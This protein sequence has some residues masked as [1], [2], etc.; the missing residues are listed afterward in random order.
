MRSIAAGVLVLSLPF[1][2][3]APAQTADE[4]V[5][6]HIA[7]LGGRAALGKLN[8]RHSTGTVT[9]TTGMGDLSGSFESYSKSP[10]KTR[11]LMKIDTT[12]AGGPGAM[13]VEQRFD[14][15]KGWVLNS[16]QGD[17]EMTGS[18]LENLRNG[19]FPTPLL[20]LKQAGVQVA[21]KPRETLKGKEAIV[22]VLT[23]TSG[24]PIR[25]YLDPET[26][27]V[28]RLVTT[29]SSPQMGGDFEQ[30]SDLSDY[31]TVDGVKVP[32]QTVNANSMQTLTIKLTTVEHNVP[33]DDAMF[34][35][36]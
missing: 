34:V 13:V 15:T 19:G 33:I 11:A 6:K 18:L 25:I 23:P 30:T 32:F 31:H 22:L 16:L 10:N 17:T 20:T 1:A 5:E 26:Y 36:K 27:L 28:M 9:F 35:K 21:L 14:G 3:T 29:V 8:S 24:P 4:I 2:A 7:A 12:A